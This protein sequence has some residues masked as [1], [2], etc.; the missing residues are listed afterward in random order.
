MD[1]VIHLKPKHT[2]FAE[3]AETSLQE[4]PETDGAI[5][6]VFDKDGVMETYRFTNAQQTA[7]AA[8]RLVK[9]ANDDYEEN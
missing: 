5:I 4:H 1:N 9:L 3:M 8:A 6:V 2:T 7:M